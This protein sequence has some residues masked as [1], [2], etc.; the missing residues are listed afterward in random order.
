MSTMS[1]QKYSLN[2]HIPHPYKIMIVWSSLPI[3][4]TKIFDWFTQVGLQNVDSR[5]ISLNHGEEI[6]RPTFPGNIIW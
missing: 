5:G 4:P 1:L 2:D 3:D 6:S